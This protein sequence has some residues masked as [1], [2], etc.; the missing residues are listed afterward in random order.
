MNITKHN[1]NLYLISF[2]LIYLNGNI[3]LFVLQY[4]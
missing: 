3:L 4:Y 1:N 2:K